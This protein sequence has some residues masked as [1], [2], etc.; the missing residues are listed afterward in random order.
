MWSLPG[1]PTSSAT[2]FRITRTRHSPSLQQG[3]VQRQVFMQLRESTKRAIMTHP[4]H[5]QKPARLDTDA[6]LLSAAGIL[7][8]QGRITA[9]W[10]RALTPMRENCWPSWRPSR[11]GA[12]DEV[13]PSYFRSHGQHDQCHQHPAQP[14]KSPHQ[15]LDRSAT[16]ITPGVETPA[17][18]NKPS[19]RTKSPPR[20]P[21]TRGA[22]SKH[23][24]SVFRC[25]YV[26]RHQDSC[27]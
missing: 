26:V 27:L 16:G 17:R 9:V 15:P 19:R 20:L 23:H 14:T 24:N 21:Q 5:D 4:N 7:T 3:K 1:T 25:I 10:A 12:T 11:S 8:Q 18:T 6:S 13:A 22:A 2:T